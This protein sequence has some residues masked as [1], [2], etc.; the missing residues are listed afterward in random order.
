MTDVL[1]DRLTDLFDR[2]AAAIDVDEDL[3]RA[4]GGA[5]LEPRRARRR[6][7]T[8]VAAAAA[9]VIAVA[10]TVGVMQFVDRD[11]ETT[12]AEAP[13]DPGPLYVLPG[14]SDEWLPGNGYTSSGTSPQWSG[15]VV[16]V[17]A[18]GL[19]LDPVAV[20][21]DTEAPPMFDPETW[22]ELSIEGGEAFLSPEEAPGRM[23]V[24]QRGRF[25]LSTT[26]DDQMIS[27][28]F[29]AFEAIEVDEAGA[30][31]VMSSDLAVITTYDVGAAAGHGT[32]AELT[33]PDRE[34]VVVETHSGQ[35]S[36]VA[37]LATRASHLEHMQINGVDGW[38]ASGRDV[39]GEWHSLAWEFAPLQT[40]FMESHLVPFDTLLAL[41]EDLEVVDEAMWNEA[42]GAD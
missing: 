24:Q 40:V 18:D 2:V 30:L 32:Y 19:Y 4:I 22:R 35:V 11:P 38:H 33:G 5:A 28:V 13:V 25:W 42:S 8:W 9:A 26:R 23:V 21:V 29:A 17:D 34:L 31:T 20:N 1:D 27:T 10:G 3:E 12:V 6:G 39:D 7:R 15:I 16:G 14:D 41:A 36:A 37:L